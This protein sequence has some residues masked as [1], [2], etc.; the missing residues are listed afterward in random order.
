M[1]LN[2]TTLQTVVRAAG[3]LAPVLNLSREA[4]MKIPLPVRLAAMHGVDELAHQRGFIRVRPDRSSASSLD[5][6]WNVMYNVKH[7]S[8]T[9]ISDEAMKQVMVRVG[10]ESSIL[11]S[12]RELRLST[13]L[14]CHSFDRTRLVYS[15]GIIVMQY[16]NESESYLMR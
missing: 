5:E 15:D 12:L 8:N 11:A 6:I 3:I 4:M 7:G 16:S 13:E 1:A 10:N 14:I 9:L 2:L